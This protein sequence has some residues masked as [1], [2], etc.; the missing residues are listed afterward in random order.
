MT[1][2]VG[3]YQRGAYIPLGLLSGWPPGARWRRIVYALSALV[4]I[5]RNYFYT[6]RGIVTRNSDYSD[7]YVTCFATVTFATRRDCLRFGYT[8]PAA[9]T[10]R[11]PRVGPR[12][13]ESA[14]RRK[15]F[16][17]FV[18]LR[19]IRESYL[20]Y[21]IEEIVSNYPYYILGG[22]KTRKHFGARAAEQSG[23]R[24]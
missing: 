13:P 16:T 20:L 1:T 18:P 19:E 24:F 8:I 5:V 23:R 6:V 9:E 11:A 2:R 12:D 22:A 14:L 15:V 10:R 7:K 4:D 17:D 3:I 21:S